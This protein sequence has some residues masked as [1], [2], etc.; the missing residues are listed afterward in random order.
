MMKYKATLKPARNIPHYAVII[1]CLH[2]KG[3]DQ[4][5]ALDELARRGLWLTAEMKAQAGLT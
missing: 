5:E 1:R 2:C 4:R 3:N